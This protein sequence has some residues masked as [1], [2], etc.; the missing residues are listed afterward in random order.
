MRAHTRIGAITA[1]LALASLGLAACGSPGDESASAGNSAGTTIVTSTST[2][3]SLAAAIA[4]D[5]FTID[6]LISDPAMDPHHYETSPRD[7]A[8]IQDA[9][10]VLYNGG[11]YDQ[12]IADALEA[13]SSAPRSINAYDIHLEH[14]HEADPGHTGDHDGHGEGS[15]PDDA[16]HDDHDAHDEGEHEAGDRHGEDG[17]DAPEGERGH[18]DD[19]GHGPVNEHIWFDLHTMSAVA[20]HL[21]EELSEMNPEGAEAYQANAAA[22]NERIDEIEDRAASIRTA[23]EG[24][25]VAQTEP[26]TEYLLAALGFVDIAPSEFVLAVE[27]G[28]DPAASVTAAFSD[29]LDDRE[30]AVLMYNATR[31]SPTTRIMRDRAEASGTPIVAVTEAVP[32]G[33]D[34]VEWMDSILDSVSEA[35][36]QE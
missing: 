8:T 9:D 1:S 30:A 35:L 5:D 20:D 21:A 7:I 16:D 29:L 11:G 12:F 17:H 18:D 15:A 28:T 23:H 3:A 34:Y 13:T 36:D 24:T 25:E 33:M 2:W 4:G 26:L 6:A 32:A 22:F 31:E 19:H 27:N 14:D 10:L